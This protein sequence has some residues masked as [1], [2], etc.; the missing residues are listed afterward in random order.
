MDKGNDI[1][2]ITILPQKH[3]SNVWDCQLFQLLFLLY[4]EPYITIHITHFVFSLG[5]GPTSHA[6]WMG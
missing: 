1:E 2:Q 3:F 5:L 6:R 4:L